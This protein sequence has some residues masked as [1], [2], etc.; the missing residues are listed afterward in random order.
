VKHKA[1]I[2]SKH[3]LQIINLTPQKVTINKHTNKWTKSNLNWET[4][5]RG[6]A[7]ILWV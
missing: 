2:L 3:A 7:H 4:Y 5:K 1:H 6:I